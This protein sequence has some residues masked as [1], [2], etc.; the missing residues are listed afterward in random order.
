MYIDKNISFLRKREKMTQEE[1]G[2]KIGVSKGQVSLYEKGK[3]DISINKISAIAN[4]F[5]VDIGDIVTKD[6]SQK[7]VVKTSNQTPKETNITVDRLFQELEKKTIAVA[8]QGITIEQLLA[9][10]ADLKA[11]YP[12][13]PWE[14][15]DNIVKN[16]E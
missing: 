1:L 5:N 2:A 15:W 12:D 14:E 6:L 11:K 13:A 16:I 7:E 4:L 9:I 8:K 3:T 10:G